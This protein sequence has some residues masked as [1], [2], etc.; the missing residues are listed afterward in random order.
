M[1]SG[2]GSQYFQ[3]GKQLF[4][5]NNVFRH[6]FEEADHMSGLSI[7]NY[8]YDENHK[9]SQ[10]FLDL[11]LSHPAIFMIE[12]ALTQV[13]LDNNIKPDK[14]LGA[15]VG[16]FAAAVQAGMLTF[17]NGLELVIH[18]AEA[19]KKK[20]PPGGM[21]AILENI[22]LYENKNYLKENS[23]LAGIN[24]SK[25]FVI[26]AKQDN[27]KIIEENLRKDK[28][29]FQ[30]LPVGFP[31]HSSFID[32]AKD[33]FLEKKISPSTASIPLVTCVEGSVLLSVNLEHF[34][35]IVRQPIL[36][37]KTIQKLEADSPAIYID[38]GP[39]GTLATS[40]KYNLPSNSSSQFFPILTPFGSDVNNINKL[41]EL[42]K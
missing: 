13:L 20:S 2:Q 38:L 17:E 33:M 15:S 18:Q 12:Y 19:L 36:F 6:Y 27:L 29:T 1:Y 26:A 35:D 40:V 41:L 25:N 30:I 28:L 14:V 21:I 23:E 3:M 16:E 9:K 11:T 22:E 39:S 31:F 5:Q 42:Q 34:W 32:P 8:L 37:Q 4:E 7:T 24:F 10:P